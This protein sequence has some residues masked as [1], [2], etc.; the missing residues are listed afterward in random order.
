MAFEGFDLS[1]FWEDSDYGRREYVAP[2]ASDDLIAEI[3]QEL[4]YRLPASYIALMKTQNGGIPKNTCCPTTSRTSWADDHIEICGIFGIGS[5]PARSLCGK[6]GSHFWVEMW[7]YPDD[8]IY[9]CDCPSAGHDMILLDYRKCGPQGEPEVVHVDQGSDY[10]TTF[11]AQ[12]FETW[13]R[14]LVHRTRYDD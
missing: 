4:G 8:G 3:E 6:L 2:P 9:L 12:N 10:A 5:E 7:E 14:S 13:I 11:L 1:N